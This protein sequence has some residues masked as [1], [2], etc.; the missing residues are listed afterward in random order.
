MGNPDPEYKHTFLSWMIRIALFVGLFVLMFSIMGLTGF[1]LYLLVTNQSTLEVVRPDH[2]HRYLNAEMKRKE[3][4]CYSQGIAF[5]GDQSVNLLVHGFLR[6]QFKW[7]FIKDKRISN[8]CMVY[9][10]E[11]L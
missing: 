2:I 10:Y 9:Y 3:E 8:A 7:R 5:V 1:H 4:Y 6:E 11:L